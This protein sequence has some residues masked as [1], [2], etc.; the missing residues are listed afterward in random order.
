MTVIVDDI[1]RV[2]CCHSSHD[3]MITIWNPKYC[4]YFY[5]IAAQLLND[6]GSTH[7]KLYRRHNGQ[8]KQGIQIKTKINQV[9]P[10]TKRRH[11]GDSTITLYFGLNNQVFNS[12]WTTLI[13]ESVQICEGRSCQRGPSGPFLGPVR[14]HCIIDE[15][16][17]MLILL[18]HTG[19]KNLLERG[20][21][22]L[23]VSVFYT[24][25]F[26]LVRT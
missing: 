1:L 2:P 13:V 21:P 15:T 20:S 4:F 16:K 26:E 3:Q 14:W 24:I 12:S 22:L 5:L 18:D 11:K 6:S 8:E 19:Q 25:S 9:I 23:Q 17:N 10:A 7:I